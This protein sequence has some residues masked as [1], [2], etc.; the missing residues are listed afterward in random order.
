[1]TRTPW[2]FGIWLFSAGMAFA[3]SPSF[4]CK[5]AKKADEI[6]ICSNEQLAKNDQLTTKAF[7]EAKAKNRKAALAA[8]RSFLKTRATCK[9]DIDCIANAQLQA[10][11]DFGML[12]AQ[13][14]RSEP[15]PATTVSTRSEIRANC[16][17]EWPGDYRMQ[18]YC[19]KNQV[20]AL[21]A[22]APLADSSSSIER[23]IVGKCAVEWRKPIGFDYRMIKYCYEKQIEAYRRLNSP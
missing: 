9:A 21:Q 22:I 5:Q 16:E 3:A 2:T 10:V 7:N 18:E 17:A 8:A 11:L 4:D 14:P 19:I 15:E 23:D 12:G 13:L 20:E 1:M 6:A